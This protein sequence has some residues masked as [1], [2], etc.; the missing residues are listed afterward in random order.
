[1]EY[2][3]GEDYNAFSQREGAVWDKLMAESNILPEGELVGALF[4][5]PYADG[6]AFYRVVSVKPL[7][8]QH[9]PYGDGWMALPSTIRGLRV[10]D[11]I[12]LVKR[13]KR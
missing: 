13:M 6:Q 10:D 1:M 7:K 9:I 4:G 3:G 5:L 2:K 12:Q 8:L 11:V